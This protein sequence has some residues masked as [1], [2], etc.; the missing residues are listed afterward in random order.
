VKNETGKY[1]T[2][3]GTQSVNT[4]DNITKSS[5]LTANYN[6]CV[7]GHYP[8]FHFYLKHTMFRILVS[9]SVFRWNLLSWAQSSELVL[10]SGHEHQYK[11]G[12]INQTQHKPSV[13]VKT[14][15]KITPRMSPRTYVHFTA[16]VKIRVLS[17]QKSSLKRYIICMVPT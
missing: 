6:H 3:E 2:E 5:K 4:N 11:I 14:N 1:S 17:E 10:I 7:S 12:Y 9:V 13:R 16:I 8:S 15:I